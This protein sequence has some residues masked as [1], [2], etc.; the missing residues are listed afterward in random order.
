M[1]DIELKN[2]EEKYI[3]FI[4]EDYNGER[5]DLSS[6]NATIQLKKYGDTTLSVDT[7][8]L[9]TNPTNGICKWL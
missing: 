4:I 7:A 3:E 6:I 5:F 9:V 1:T 2:N 8:C